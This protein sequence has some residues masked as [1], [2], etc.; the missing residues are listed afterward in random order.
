[1]VRKK[2]TDIG[3]YRL[4]S[5]RFSGFGST[6]LVTI[7]IG[8]NQLVFG[9]FSGYCFQNLDWYLSINFWYKSKTLHNH[10]QWHFC[11]ISLLWFLLKKPNCVR[12]N[13]KVRVGKLRNG[14]MLNK[15]YWTRQYSLLLAL[16]VN[17]IPAITNPGFG[18]G[19]MRFIMREPPTHPK[20]N[21]WA[22]Q[23]IRTAY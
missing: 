5:G 23:P 21:E 11:P 8:T 9:R 20:S 3:F 15:L 10:L 13:T 16:T 18:M 7:I 22:S 19:R 12:D 14:K 4:K 6:C 17:K 2:L 1:M